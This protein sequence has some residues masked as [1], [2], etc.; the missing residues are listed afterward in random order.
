VREREGGREGGRYTHTQLLIYEAFLVASVLSPFFNV[1]SKIKC[2]PVFP[3]A[4]QKFLESSPVFEMF[5]LHDFL[6]NPA[7]VRLP[8][9]NDF[10]RSTPFSISCGRIADI[11]TS[12]G[13]GK[14]GPT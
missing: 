2:I 5:A 1:C 4:E 14:V 8:A 12:G 10:D 3:V 9:A 7:W 11:E 13:V 6:R